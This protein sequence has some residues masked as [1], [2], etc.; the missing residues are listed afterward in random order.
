MRG[1]FKIGLLAV[2]GAL[3]VGCEAHHARQM[4]MHEPGYFV[5]TAV[6]VQDDRRR[7]VGT[8]DQLLP[9]SDGDV[10]FV[11]GEK[12]VAGKTPIAEFSA[13]SVYT[14]DYQRISNYPDGNGYRYR[15]GVESRISAP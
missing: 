2:T 12:T 15:M 13:V 11:R 8:S 6:V 3:S 9:S 1:M 5:P 7:G 10:W 14:Y 4:R